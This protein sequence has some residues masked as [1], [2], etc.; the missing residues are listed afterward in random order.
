M[1][2]VSFVAIFSCVCVCVCVHDFEL[3]QNYK[4]ST[5][6]LSFEIPEANAVSNEIPL[7]NSPLDMEV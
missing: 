1:V 6:F 5:A 2:L 3:C 7:C 4:N